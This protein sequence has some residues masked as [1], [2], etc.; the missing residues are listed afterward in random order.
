LLPSEY[1]ST[2]YKIILQNGGEK[3]Y[4]QI[5][6][7]YYATED[8]V[9]RKYAMNS[10]GAIRILA[11]LYWAVKSGDV[12]LQDF[13]YPIGAVGAS[14]AGCELAWKNLIENFS[15]IQSKVAKANASL[16]DAV[17]SYSTMRFCT[18][19]KATEIEAFFKANP[20]PKSERRISPSVESMRLISAFI[21]RIKESEF[22]S[23]TCWTK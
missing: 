20:L 2:V 10:L 23:E 13:F 18:A 17:V 7:T 16:M 15:L 6:D 11:T 9:E 5:K 4:K 14:P 3:K 22:M 1:K 8:K 12:K 21:D 19:E